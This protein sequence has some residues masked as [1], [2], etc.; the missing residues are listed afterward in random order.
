[1]GGYDD[2][3]GF[4]RQYPG[5]QRYAYPVLAI[6]PGAASGSATYD[7]WHGG[8][9]VVKLDGS[10]HPR[11]DAI[12]AQIRALVEDNS[13]AT[14]VLE[15][16]GTHRKGNSASSSASFARH[17]GHLE[18]LLATL[19]VVLVYVRPKAWQAAACG[20]LPLLTTQKKRAIFSLACRLYPELVQARV[21]KAGLA[22]LQVSTAD[23]VMLYHWARTRRSASQVK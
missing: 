17:Q 14:V 6:D 11:P 2:T 1:M 22:G 9:E 16:V 10:T 5:R 23:S 4:K 18:A 15:D 20:K 7:A 13:I 21:D 3:E 8:I 19:P 12:V